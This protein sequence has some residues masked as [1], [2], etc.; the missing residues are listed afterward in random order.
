MH[1]RSALVTAVLLAAITAGC[2]SPPT[3][4]EKSSVD[5]GPRPDNYEQVIREYLKTRIKDPASAVIDFRSGPKPLYQQDTFLRP[6]Q[7]GW[8]VCVFIT[9]KNK[10]GESKA[11]PIVFY[12][13]N[14][15]IVTANGG[16]DDSLIGRRY[17]LAGCNELGTPF[18]EN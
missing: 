9:D 10:D 1:L 15:I 16:P 13:R 6:L 11:Y 5:Y 8:G 2:K 3:Q 14:G 17:A 4:E 7:Y 12:L 18:V